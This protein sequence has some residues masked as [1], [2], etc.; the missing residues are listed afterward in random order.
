MAKYLGENRGPKKSK[1]QI[2]PAIATIQTAF[3]DDVQRDIKV[4]KSDKY[5]YNKGPFTY[6]DIYNKEKPDAE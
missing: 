1:V 2:Y 5:N 3:K 6:R 4:S